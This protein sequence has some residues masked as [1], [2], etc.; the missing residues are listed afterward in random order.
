MAFYTWSG[1]EQHSGTTQ[2]IRAVNVLYAL[3]GS[4]DVPG[5]NVLFTPVPT[6]P[7]AG[8]ELLDPTQRAKAIGLSDR[9]LGPAHFGFVTGEDF[10]TAALDGRPY[11][12]RALVSFGANLVTRLPSF[13][14]EARWCADSG[15]VRADGSPPTGRG[16]YTRRLTPTI[17]SKN[18]TLARS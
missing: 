3:T 2:I 18:C 1:L 15:Q 13:V 9:P 8:A 11:R 4:L 7:V 17:C 10:Y 14:A 12:A 16:C 6:N 5:G